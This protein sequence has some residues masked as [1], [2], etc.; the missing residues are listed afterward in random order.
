MDTLPSQ[1]S[2]SFWWWAWTWYPGLRTMHFLSAFLPMLVERGK[3]TWKT[4]F[5]N[6]F[7]ILRNP[8]CLPEK[9]SVSQSYGLRYNAYLANCWILSLHWFYKKMGRDYWQSCDVLVRRIA[10]AWWRVKNS[11]DVLSYKEWSWMCLFGMWQWTVLK[12]NSFLDMYMWTYAF[13]DKG[14]R[15]EHEL[16]A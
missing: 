11:I 4:R 10:W 15:V 5:Q 8:R 14:K 3:A 2:S 13:S 16:R 9:C 12:R 6:G 1:W 7:R